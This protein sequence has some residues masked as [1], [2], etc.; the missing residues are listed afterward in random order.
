LTHSEAVRLITEMAK[1]GVWFKEYEEALSMAV[2]DMKALD[3]PACKC[4]NVIIAYCTK[5]GAYLPNTV[6][7]GK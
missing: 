2:Q 3:Y 1:D 6:R 4:G 5:C 7:G